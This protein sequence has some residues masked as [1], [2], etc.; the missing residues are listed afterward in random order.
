MT[1][2]NIVAYA[3]LNGLDAVAVSDHNAID[4]VEVALKAGEQFN[5][6]VVPA[7]E[8]QTSE[9]IH[10]LCL[11]EDFASLKAY[12]ESF[13]LVKVANKPSVF[14]NQLIVDEDDNTVGELED[15]LLMNSTANAYEIYEEVQRYGGIAIPAHIDREGNGMLAILG[16]IPPEF[17]TVELSEKASGEIRREYEA[18]RNVVIDSDAHT[19]NDIGEGHVMEVTELSPKGIIAAIRAAEPKG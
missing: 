10:V 18:Q 1:P 17:K 2:V 13:E 9:E 6:T 19:L 4:N 14:G 8:V 16:V 15:L 5:V 7:V 3:S 11:F 12:R